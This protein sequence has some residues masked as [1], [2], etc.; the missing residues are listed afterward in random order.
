ML[1]REPDL[2]KPNQGRAKNWGKAPIGAVDGRV[3]AT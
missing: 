1:A 2:V 3:Y